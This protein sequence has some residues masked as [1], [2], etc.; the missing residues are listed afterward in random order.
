[1]QKAK[2]ELRREDDLSS[3]DLF[4]LILTKE[5]FDKECLELDSQGY[6]KEIGSNPSRIVMFHDQAFHVLDELK[7]C[8]LDLNYD[9]CLQVDATGFSY[10]KQEAP[11]D[12]GMHFYYAAVV[13]SPVLKEPPVALF[14]MVTTDNTAYS[15]TSF[16]LRFFAA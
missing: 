1:M 10:K 7:R 12:G 15:L 2:S 5:I 11:L 4:D 3:T 13:K 6:I 14:E 9:L 16:Y 8:S